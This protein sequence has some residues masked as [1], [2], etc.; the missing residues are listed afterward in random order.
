MSS[1]TII[2][3]GVTGVVHFNSGVTNF[4]A[5]KDHTCQR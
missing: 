5:A 3:A 4:D 1:Q 2:H